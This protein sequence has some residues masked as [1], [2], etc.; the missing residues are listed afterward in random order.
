MAEKTASRGKCMIK[1]MKNA[2]KH[3]Y[4][5]TGKHPL[6]TYSETVFTKF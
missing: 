4:S 1:R 3:N 2:T 5:N 6:T